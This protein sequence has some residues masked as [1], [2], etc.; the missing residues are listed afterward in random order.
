MELR[1]VLLWWRYTVHLQLIVYYKVNE[2]M[3]V[4]TCTPLTA[5][6]TCILSHPPSSSSAKDVMK[7]SLLPT[8]PL[9]HCK[10]P[11]RHNCSLTH[12]PEVSFIVRANSF[13]HAWRCSALLE[14]L[15]CEWDMLYKA[16]IRCHCNG[17]S[18]ETLYVSS[19]RYLKAPEHHSSQAFKGSNTVL[20][21]M[22]NIS[23]IQ[24]SMW[25][26][27]PREYCSKSLLQIVLLE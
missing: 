25:M 4:Y 5:T 11:P 24:A 21:A 8:S 23:Q 16:F 27:H 9:W 20:E 10:S 26:K 2:Q 17:K 15:H 18:Q 1:T 14:T 6:T 22:T 19:C 13:L 3:C 12:S 7:P